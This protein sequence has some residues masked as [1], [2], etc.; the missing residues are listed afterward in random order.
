MDWDFN[1]LESL[2]QRRGE[3]VIHEIAVA[4]PACRN[5]DIYAYSTT[6]VDGRVGNIRSLSCPQCMGDGYMYRDAQLVTGLITSIQPG[7]RQLT[8]MGYAV[9]GDA[10]FSP[11]LNTRHI[12]DFDRITF[13]VS[14]EVSGG[15]VILRGAATSGDNAQRATDLTEQ[16]DRLWYLPEC[17]IWCE[18]Q[19]GV[20]YHEGTDFTFDDKKIVWNQGP[21]VGTLYTIKY[22][23]YLEWVSYASPMERYDR[24]RDLAQKV[25]LRKKHVHF[26]DGNLADSPDDRSAQQEEFTTQIKI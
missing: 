11:S 22:R 7:N 24:G 9:P 23:A 25:M 16:Q 5:D 1:N 2:I 12:G 8:D 26:Q 20:I 21:V 17:T 19:N 4:C 13:Q 6:D 18:D 14:T 15:Q 3:E 10:V